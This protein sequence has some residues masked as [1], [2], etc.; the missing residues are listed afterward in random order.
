MCGLV[1]V[2]GNLFMQERKAFKQLLVLDEMRGHHSTGIAAVNKKNQIAIDKELG[3]P[4]WLLSNG[5]KDHAFLD[6]E[7]T[8]KPDWNILIGHNR[9]ATVGKKTAENAHPFQHGHVV[10][11]HNGTL[12]AGNPGKLDDYNKFEVD[13][14]AVIY[15]IN[16][17]GA[18]A[19]K[20]VAGAY[21]L[22]WYDQDK[23][24]LF[25]IRN[26]NKDPK[27]TRPLY[28][29]RRKDKDAFFWASESW[30][31][32][33]C[34]DRNSIEYEEIKEFED[35]K[36]YSL[37]C[38]DFSMSHFRNVNMEV[39]ETILG[40]TP[41][42][43]A[44]KVIRHGGQNTQQHMGGNNFSVY[45]SGHN[46]GWKNNL[47]PFRN[48][49]NVEA[50]F[51]SAWDMAALKRLCGSAIDFTIIGDGVGLTG[52]EFL[53]GKSTIPTDDFQIRIYNNS[54]KAKEFDALTDGNHTWNAVLKKPVKFWNKKTHK[55]ELYVLV[56]MR[57]LKKSK[58][59]VKEFGNNTVIPFYPPSLSTDERLEKLDNILNGSEPLIGYQ[60]RFL[61]P[62]EWYKC[63]KSGCSNCQANAIMSEH[64]YLTWISHDEFICYDCKDLDHVK[65]YIQN[66]TLGT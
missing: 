40:F 5:G 45:N 14:E 29:T 62:D 61:N 11:A 26:G 31:L 13:S 37:D 15:N 30:M 8:P 33:V 22:V 48:N 56:D 21:A 51:K 35:D 38:S 32:E 55:N 17:Y 2:A 1:G 39:G 43:P 34:L 3:H 4:F 23:E 47:N 18:E 19:I 27:K 50:K 9:W 20:K 42:P 60:G 63:T 16:K 64:A 6:D 53:I 66:L 58:E 65:P 12:I 59:K 10:G 7:G 24:K 52:Q 36:L 46:G 25:F 49:A 41:P 54:T 44:K 57:T 28:Y